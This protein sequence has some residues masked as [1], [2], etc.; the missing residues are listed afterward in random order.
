MMTVKNL[1]EFV[2]LE[3]GQRLTVFDNGSGNVYRAKF[4]T[5]L[6][7]PLRKGEEIY[8]SEVVNFKVSDDGIM[9]W[10]D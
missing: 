2:V 5:V 1:L 7:A 9:V 10:I 4:D 6:D 8:S 3:D